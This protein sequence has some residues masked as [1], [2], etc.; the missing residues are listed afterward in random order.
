MFF[1]FI[2][3]ESSFVAKR[4]QESQLLVA[5]RNS[6]CVLPPKWVVIVTQFTNYINRTIPKFSFDLLGFN[7]LSSILESYVLN[8]WEATQRLLSQ[9]FTIHFINAPRLSHVF[10]V[11]VQLH[12]SAQTEG[13][14]T[15]AVMN[16]WRKINLNWYLFMTWETCWMMVSKSWNG[17]QCCIVVYS[18]CD[19][20]HSILLTGSNSF[21]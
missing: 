9:L 4:G 6:C 15:Q 10:A 1:E 16:Y 12:W 14:A 21:E 18:E 11:I 17:E 3:V 13:F 8:G 20:S 5:L 2:S 7:A 19:W